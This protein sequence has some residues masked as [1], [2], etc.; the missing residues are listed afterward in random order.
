M[1]PSQTG[2]Y[3]WARM[4]SSVQNI[5]V[6]ISCWLCRMNCYDTIL[7][8]C[9]FKSERIPCAFMMS[10]PRI[11]FP[12]MSGTIILWPIPVVPTLLSYPFHHGLCITIC[13]H[14]RGFQ[15]GVTNLFFKPLRFKMVFITFVLIRK[16]YVL[17]L[18]VSSM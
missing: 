10:I 13:Y 4:T 6:Y 14:H 18:I 11:T 8:T 5:W 16:S 7:S 2:S 3:L 12:S 15:W 1:Q 9:W 17:R